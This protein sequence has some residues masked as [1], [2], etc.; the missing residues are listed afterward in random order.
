MHKSGNWTI[1]NLVDFRWRDTTIYPHF[2][3]LS[4]YDVYARVISLIRFKDYRLYSTL[5]GQGILINR[6]FTAHFSLK[7][8]LYEFTYIYIYIYICTLRKALI[9]QFGVEKIHIYLLRNISA[10][11][12]LLIFD[13]I[14]LAQLQ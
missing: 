10:R 14:Q 11:N 1:R 2:S 5:P 12:F 7:L 8:T 9:F 13:F 4:K 6:R 3:W